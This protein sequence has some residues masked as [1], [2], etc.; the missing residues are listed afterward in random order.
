M[1]GGFDLRAVDDSLFDELDETRAG[2]GDDFDFAR[3]G[4]GMDEVVEFFTR[5]GCLGSEDTDGA[6]LG[7]VGGGLD[8]RLHADEWLREALASRGNG[9]DGGGVAGDDDDA[10]A[11]LDEVLRE[12]EDAVLDLRRGF[13]AVGAVGGVTDVMNRM[14]GQQGVDFTE[15]REAAD[16]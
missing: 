10:R 4:V 15:H 1:N 14:I 12:G 8:G 13:G 6:C 2:L 7:A 11:L 16:A 5:D 9:V 3:F